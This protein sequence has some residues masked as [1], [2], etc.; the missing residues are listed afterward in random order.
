MGLL[1]NEERRELFRHIVPFLTREEL[2]H[3][4]DTNPALITEEDCR[5]AKLVKNRDYRALPGDR[6]KTR[7]V[8]FP[9]TKALRYTDYIVSFL[10]VCDSG[11]YYRFHALDIPRGLWCVLTGE[12]KVALLQRAREI[13]LEDIRFIEETRREAGKISPPIRASAAYGTRNAGW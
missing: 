13:L 2:T 9:R 8:L 7:F 12:T 6:T 10:G 4:V 5:R 3:L 11:G 1:K